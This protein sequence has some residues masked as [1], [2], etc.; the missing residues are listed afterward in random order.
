MIE[1]GPIKWLGFVIIVQTVIIWLY[2]RGIDY[3]L[4]KILKKLEAET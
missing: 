1:I 4:E 3:N 2:L